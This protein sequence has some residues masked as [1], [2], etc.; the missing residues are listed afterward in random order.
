LLK[1]LESAYKIYGYEN[2]ANNIN[3]YKERVIGFYLDSCK[4]ILNF[5]LDEEL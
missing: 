1:R 4:G 5:T 2:N 3:I